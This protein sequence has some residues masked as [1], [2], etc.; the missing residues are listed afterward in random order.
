M[1]ASLDPT[2]VLSRVPAE[3]E[4]NPITAVVAP[5]LDMAGDCLENCMV[6]SQISPPPA[7]RLQ[8]SLRGQH[9]AATL[10]SF[11]PSTTTTVESQPAAVVSEDT[12]VSSAL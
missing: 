8:F 2:D 4:C 3:P 11:H 7:H 6:R 5:V 12:C 1:F 10:D 9:F